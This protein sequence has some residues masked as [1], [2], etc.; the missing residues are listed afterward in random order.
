M[1]RNNIKEINSYE[2]H[3]LR[4][5]GDIKE[6]DCYN[7]ENLY[8]EEGPINEEATLSHLQNILKLIT[9]NENENN[10]K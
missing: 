5:F 10:E 6:E 9:S 3:T 8:T 7:F 4:N 1:V 2:V